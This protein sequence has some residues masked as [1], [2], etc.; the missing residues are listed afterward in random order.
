MSS[1]QALVRSNAEVLSLNAT[2]NNTAYF[3]ILVQLLW[4]CLVYRLFLFHYL[5]YSIIIEDTSSPVH[6]PSQ[7]S[8]QPGNNDITS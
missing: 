8:F 7:Q 6:M 2:G 1:L 5:T 4:S 3:F